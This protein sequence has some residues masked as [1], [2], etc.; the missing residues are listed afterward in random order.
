MTGTPL[1]RGSH[2]SP[3][4]IPWACAAVAFLSCLA[5]A[6]VTPPFQAPD[7]PSHYAYA[8]VL[9]VTGEPPRQGQTDLPAWS[10]A[11][12]AALDA[13]WFPQVRANPGGKPP[14]TEAERHRLEELLAKPLRDDDGGGEGASPTAGYPPLY[15]ALL[16]PAYAVVKTAGGD[17]IERLTAMRFVSSLLTALMVLLVFMFVRELVPGAPLVA[18]VGALGVGLLP[19]VGFIGS[20]VN[21]DV[22]ATTLAATLFYLLALSFR[23]GLSLGRAVAIGALLVA[24]WATK[25]IFLGLVPG[26]L[27]G[28]ALL[29]VVACRSDRREGL[30]VAL[31]LAAS[32]LASGLI[33]LLVTKGLWGRA[34]EPAG[35]SQ[36]VRGATPGQPEKSISGFLSYA[37]QYWLPRLPFLTDQVPE[38]YPAWETMFKGFVGRFGWLEFQFPAWLYWV[39]LA[40]WLA[41][42]ALAARALVLGRSVLRS[43]LPELAVYVLMAAGVL[44]LVAAV[45]YQLRLDGNGFEQARYLFPLLPLLGALIGLAV[46]GAGPRLAP[47]LGVAIVLGTGALNIGGLLLTLGRYYA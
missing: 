14:W 41:L 42:L 20:S 40:W 43:R 19:Y 18:S 2:V 26:A 27:A 15:Y 44:G 46:K 28:L 32:A 6:W 4:W 22:L 23:R 35:A 29:L 25:P 34:A 24:G 9:A 38:P 33:Y 1:W 30:S 7:E 45:G 10:S 39:A 47:Y 5:W 16:V 17:V 3:R 12:F 13:V 11:E 8:E 37:W 21:N 36:F 31:S